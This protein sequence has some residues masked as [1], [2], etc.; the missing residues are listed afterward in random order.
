M[1]RR[2]LKIGVVAPASRV[3]AEVPAQVI[4]LSA[5]LYPDPAQT[6]DI[7]FHPQCFLSHGH[8]AGADPARAEAFLDVA[9]D[10]SYDAVWFGRGG[11]GSCRIAESVC[12]RLAPAAL[13]KTYLGYSDMGTLLAGLYRAGCTV[14]HGP[15]P[16]DIRRA[17]GDAAVARALAWLVD[18]DPTSLESTLQPGAPH[19]AFNLTILSQL[20]GTPM[21]PDLKDH[22]LLLEDV[23]EYQY[24]LDRTFFHVTSHPAIREIAGL[25]LGR[26]TDIPDNDPDFAM[27][28]EEIA[29]DWCARAGI[30][31][32]G[33]A[34]IGHDADNKVVPFGTL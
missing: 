19:A 32:L 31:Y 26:C 20:L 13:A 4:A 17:G 8:F 15:M 23:G 21:Q 29:R 25:R 30:A 6:P 5:A 9:N 22:I 1:N 33:S 11:Y 28:P 2:K 7:V 27:T 34:D 12:A 24:R 3:E 18:R 10:P 14:A 16:H